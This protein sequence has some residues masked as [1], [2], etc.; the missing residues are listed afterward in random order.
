MNQLSLHDRSRREFLRLGGLAMPW[1]AAGGIVSQVAAAAGGGAMSTA[2]GFGKAKS[3]ILVFCCGGQSQ[4]ETWDPKP[5]APEQIRGEFGTIAT[6][7]PGTFFGEYLPQTAKLADRFTV[8]RSMSHVDLDHGSATY[9]TLTGKYHRKISG[10]PPP[11]PTD[12]PTLGAALRAIRRNEKFPHDAVHL[13]APSWCRSFLRP[14]SMPA[15]WDRRS[16]R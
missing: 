11:L 13:N 16:N 4:F 10:N 5:D 3:V 14:V 15:S 9:L 8:V 7:V 1:L 2:P 6:S 12:E